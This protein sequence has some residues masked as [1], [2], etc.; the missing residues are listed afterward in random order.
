VKLRRNEEK[1]NKRKTRQKKKQTQR[2]FG[3][4]NRERE[5]NEHRL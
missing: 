2:I 5:T 3:S 1:K 4:F